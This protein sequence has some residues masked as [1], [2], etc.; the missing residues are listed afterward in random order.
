MNHKDDTVFEQWY[1]ENAFD[2]ARDPI[3][4]RDCGLMRKAWHAALAT[5]STCQC[6]A[7]APVIHASDCA[8][9]NMPAYPNIPC[10]CGALAAP[11]KAGGQSIDIQP[12]SRTSAEYKMV[13]AGLPVGA[14]LEMAEHYV[15]HGVRSTILAAQIRAITTHLHL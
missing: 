14:V 1:A 4:S 5:S 3:G 6:A 9:H 13:V 12:E 15:K 7:C 11:Q 10:D 2:F 8:V